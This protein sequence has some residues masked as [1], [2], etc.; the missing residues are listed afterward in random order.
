MLNDVQG[1]EKWKE[2]LSFASEEL[3]WEHEEIKLNQIYSSL[4]G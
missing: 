2:N 3:C 1:Y 4:A